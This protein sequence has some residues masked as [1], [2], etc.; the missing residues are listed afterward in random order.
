MQANL[1][2]KCDRAPGKPVTAE[3]QV[4]M[5]FYNSFAELD[6]CTAGVCGL[7]QFALWPVIAKDNSRAGSPPYK[8]PPETTV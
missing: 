3:K 6:H 8:D 1:P 4:F 2:K 7:F 5:K